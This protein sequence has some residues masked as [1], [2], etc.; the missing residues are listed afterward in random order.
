[1][2]SKP[3]VISV[4]RVMTPS[5]N[6]LK[7]FSPTWVTA[8]LCGRILFHRHEILIEAIE[9]FGALSQKLFNKIV[10]FAH[11]WF[12]VARRLTGVVTGV[13]IAMVGPL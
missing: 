10:C 4:S 8:I 3:V 1:M 11:G 6:R 9:V 7:R 13:V 12:P 5:R 2:V